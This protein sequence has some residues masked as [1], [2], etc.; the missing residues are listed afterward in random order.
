MPNLDT[1]SASPTPTTDVDP[2]HHLLLKSSNPTQRLPP[3]P[4]P[5]RRDP[6]STSS[7]TF[8]TSHRSPIQSLLATSNL[9]H[10]LLTI[11][12]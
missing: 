4:Y 6:P 2:T 5:T 12:H 3:Q 9:P 11:R 8:W 10:P 1:P 7:W